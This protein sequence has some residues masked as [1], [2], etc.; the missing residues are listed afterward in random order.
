MF[1]VTTW[2]LIPEVLQYIFLSSSFC[3]FLAPVCPPPTPPLIPFPP[4]FPFILV[5]LLCSL[6]FRWSQWCSRQNHWCPWWHCSQVDLWWGLSGKKT[7]W[8]WLPR[9]GSGGCSKGKVWVEFWLS[10]LEADLCIWRTWV[11]IPCSLFQGLYEGVT[12]VFTQPVKGQQNAFAEQHMVNCA[13][14]E[15]R[16]KRFYLHLQEQRKGGCGDLWRGRGRESWV[17]CW[18]QRGAWLISPAPPSLLYRSE[19]QED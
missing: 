1:R 19:S 18:D 6:F 7:N 16:N 15:A 14:L 12:G 4:S 3:H 10:A 13:K 8:P 17:S 9:P 5:S 11:H 2:K